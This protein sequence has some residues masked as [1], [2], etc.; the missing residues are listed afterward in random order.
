MLHATLI[1][2]LEKKGIEVRAEENTRF[3]Y[4]DGP[5]REISWINQG[6]DAICL[7]VRR[8]NDHSDLHTDYHAGSFVSSIKMAFEWAGIK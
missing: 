7:K 1:K 2:R 3:H 4:A 6:G 8:F 5:E